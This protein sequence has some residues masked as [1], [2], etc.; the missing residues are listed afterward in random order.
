V[1]DPPST[2]GDARSRLIERLERAVELASQEMR[3]DFLNMVRPYNLTL[4][5][6][7]V[8]L[9]LRERGEPARISELGDATLT[10][11][12]SMT[13]AIDRLEQDGLIARAGDSNDRRASLVALTP[14]GQQIVDEIDRAHRLYF[15]K[16][17]EALS[18]SELELLVK[19]FERF[20]GPPPSGA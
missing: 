5:Q 3:H 2:N 16:R 11:P 4:T 9:V 20:S 8:L 12:S 13:H 10:P 15:K 14:A 17:C 7:S 6:V 1:T 19:M 18:E